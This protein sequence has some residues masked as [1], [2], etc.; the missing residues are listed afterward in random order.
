MREKCWQVMRCSKT[1]CPA[2]GKEEQRCWLVPDTHCRDGEADGNAL[3][4]MEQCLKC[5]H[6]MSSV[7]QES[8]WET[9]NAV[10][11]HFSEYRLLV[12]ARELENHE[13][14]LEM[15]ICLSQSF[16]MLKKISDGDPYVRL[17]L[18]S[19][20]EMLFKQ[21]VLLNEMAENYEDMTNQYQELAIGICVVYD[22]LSR[23]AGGDRAARAPTNSPNELVAKLGLLVNNQAAALN[24][25]L[26]DVE[27]TSMEL[28]L[29]LSENFDVLKKVSEGNLSARAG[30]SSD[31]ELIAK[32]GTVVNQTAARLQNAWRELEASKEKLED[33][34]DG[35]TKEL[36]EAQKATLNILED[37]EDSKIY[38]ENVIANFLDCLIVVNMD[39]TIHS[40]NGVALDLL[41][42]REKEVLDNGVAMFLGDGIAE[43][44]FDAKKV[45]DH[46]VNFLAKDGRLIPM[47]L[48]A[49][50]MSERVGESQALVIIAKDITGRKH[51][52]EEL[53]KARDAADAGNR[54]KSEFLANMS[55]EIRTPM[56]GVIGMTDLALG[57]DLDEEQREY[58]ETVKQS[59][60]SLLT[61]INDI[62]DFSK[63]EAN[64]LELESIPFNLRDSLNDTIKPLALRVHE[65]GLEMVVDV[66]D[67]VPDALQG[68]S[69]R[70][71]QVIINLIGNAVKFTETG[72]VFLKVMA[73]SVTDDE[74][75]LHIAVRDTGVGIPTEKQAHIFNHFSQ[76][77]SSTT[78]RFGGSGLGLTISSRLANLMGGRIWVESEVGQGSTFH[79]TALLGVQ[80]DP[81]LKQPALEAEKLEGMGVL[82][83]DDNGTNLKI[84]KDLTLRWRMLPTVF[85]N[86]PAALNAFE[87]RRGGQNPFLLVLLDAMMPGMDG[88]EVASR[89]RASRFCSD[90]K[91]IML[92]SAGQYG[93]AG[94]WRNYGIDACLIKP[95]SQRLLL[96]T[97]LRVLGCAIPADLP[98]APENTHRVT[99]GSRKLQILLAEDNPVNQKMAMTFLRKRGHEVVLANNGQVALDVLATKRF[100]LI[101][102]DVQM[103]EMDGFRA[104]AAIRERERRAGSSRIPI[105]AMTAHAMKGDRERCLEVGMDDYVSKPIRSGELFEAIDRLVPPTVRPG[106]G[107][108][109]ARAGQCSKP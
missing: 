79:F 9:F 66:H 81:V 58:L 95:A 44:L 39:G 1:D 59:A 83:V 14:S 22:A 31:N 45:K 38:I 21:Q 72:E 34:V 76:V 91:I 68:D 25:L 28:A 101:L 43:D 102:M 20:N 73:D 4:K 42:Y 36:A 61:V 67:G 60:D 19:G 97:I 78:R 55:H 71:A 26:E 84:L 105:M 18:D 64:K 103:P 23:I 40:I 82:V 94:H 75:L 37:L 74:V 108:D 49:S 77:D 11:R 107:D 54:A 29:G 62:L 10:S 90:V 17:K 89:I 63:I 104:T 33:R 41:G 98:A 6:F 12:E 13:L 32:L 70:L 3:A 100:D 15:A 16:G 52:E 8:M 99:K 51:A 92:T 53:R 86:G 50:L 96:E 56:N 69:G 27:S 93:A 47:I 7:D 88:F 106:A 5:K 48:S 30:E 65:K 35:R 87:R 109:P 85:D 46:E 2:F 80:K 57:T 24:G